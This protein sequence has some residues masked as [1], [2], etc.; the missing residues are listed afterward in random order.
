MRAQYA[1]DPGH[2]IFA[3]LPLPRPDEFLVVLDPLGKKHRSTK[4]RA[5]GTVFSLILCVFLLWI[6]F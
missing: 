2:P 5:A 3:H 4:K 1:S 6:V